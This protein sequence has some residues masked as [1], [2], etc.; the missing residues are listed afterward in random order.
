MII[1]VAE[2]NKRKKNAAESRRN[3]IKSSFDDQS[4]EW[5]R[6]FLILGLTTLESIVI[7][8]VSL[9][10]LIVAV[11]LRSVEKNQ[12]V[13]TEVQDKNCVPRYEWHAYRLDLIS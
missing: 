7:H 9:N 4:I 2:E 6:K 12:I 10:I 8:I 1:C 11:F 5:K 13:S 3:A